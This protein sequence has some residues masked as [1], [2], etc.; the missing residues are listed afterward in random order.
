MNSSSSSQR[1][2][3]AGLV[4]QEDVAEA[5]HRLGLARHRPAGIEIGVEGAAG[6]DP[7]EH[8]DAADFD[9]PVAVLRA[10]A[11][12][13]GI[14]NDFAHGRIYESARP[15]QTSDDAREPRRA[16]RRAAPPV[17]MTK[18]ARARFSGIG[19][20]QREDLLELLRGHAR[21]G[22]HP[23]ALDFGRRRDDRDLVDLRRAAFFEQQGMSST[24]SGAIGIARRGMSRARA[25]PPG[26]SAPRA[27]RSAPRVAEH[28]ARRAL[29]D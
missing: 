18:S 2:S 7:V 10:E 11:G 15:R 25:R 5:V 26:G 28:R 20:L 12:G 27:A 19:H 13:L 24:T 9:H 21:A 1:S 23:R 3:K 16:S 6:L 29:C 4:G 8:L 22:Q 17:S 14:E